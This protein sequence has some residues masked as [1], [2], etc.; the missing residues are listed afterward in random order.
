MTN[1]PQAKPQLTAEVVSIGD[2]M[3][4]GA[5]LDTNAQWL[6]RR[7]GELG[8][9][10]TFHSTVGDTLQDNIDV[11][12]I[13]AERVDVVVSTGGLGPTQD[14]LTREA[15][16]GVIGE[17]LEF[18]ESA[19]QHIQAMF[20]RRN[21]EMPARNRVQ[22][23][24]PPGSEQVFNPQGTAPG[25]DLVVARNGDS[26][27]SRIFALPGVPAEMKRMFDETVAPRILQQSGN[28]LTIK[29]SVM[30]F[31]GTG[32]S[33]MERRLGDMTSRDRQPRVGITVGTA[34]ISLRITAT[35]ETDSQCD[36]MIRGTRDEIMELV[37]EFYFGDGES[38][39]QHHAIDDMLREREQSLMVVEFGHAAPLGNWFAALGETSSYRGGLSLAVQAD[40]QRM[41]DTDDETSA[42]ESAKSRFHADWLLMVDAYPPV[43]RDRDAPEPDSDV[44]LI[45]VSP[46]G[47]RYATSI[48]IGGH[49]DV[50]HPRIAKSAMA[51]MRKIMV[52]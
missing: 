45:V 9:A 52:S 3:T 18:R 47:K 20:A 31:F 43:D 10:V 17:D 51:W 15:L 13:A 6:S 19:M 2:E 21:R 22:A 7:L 36:T 38:F 28:A 26:R 42:V 5:R 27:S 32:E 35:G 4:S 50:L 11:F 37:S 46:E 23:M 44:Q 30:K 14:D 48:V 39:E 33:D 25:V 49:P 1:P 24:F 40:L 8:I 16:A 12:R 34:T 41:F 29:H